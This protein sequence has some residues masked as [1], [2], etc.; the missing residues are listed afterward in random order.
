MKTPALMDVQPSL[1]AET[2]Q[3]CMN[4]LVICN[5][6]CRAV[7][8]RMQGGGRCAASA[9]AAGAAPG[10]LSSRLA[11]RFCSPGSRL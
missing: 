8:K 7:K 4:L 9:G 10:H 2:K 6:D 5:H 11:L 1:G 3:K